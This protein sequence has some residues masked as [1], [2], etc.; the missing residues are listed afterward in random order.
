MAPARVW[1]ST[2]SYLGNSKVCL[3]SS[4][5]EKIRIILM[6]L[7][8]FHFWSPD[9][10][11]EK[12]GATCLQHVRWSSRQWDELKERREVHYTCNTRSLPGGCEFQRAHGRIIAWSHTASKAKSLVSTP[13]YPA[14]MVTLPGIQA[15][16]SESSSPQGI[17]G[18]VL[19]KTPVRS[20]AQAK[21]TLQYKFR[22]A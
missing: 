5:L 6:L 18:P 7:F 15:L 14:L 11:S 1:S 21:V 8:I 19:H 4:N 2:R 3:L 12:E 20:A 16:A 13:H 9:Q 22:A 10:S 17:T